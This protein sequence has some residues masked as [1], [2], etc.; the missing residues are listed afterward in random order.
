MISA[1]GFDMIS[2]ANTNEWT[3]CFPTLFVFV[4]EL[5]LCDCSF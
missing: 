4:F 2:N 1:L 3:F 5:A